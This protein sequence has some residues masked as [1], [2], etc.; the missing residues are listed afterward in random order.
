VLGYVDA[1]SSA[2][3][4]YG[5][6]YDRDLQYSVDVIEDTHVETVS[7]GYWVYLFSNP[8][9]GGGPYVTSSVAYHV[10]HEG[11]ILEVK[12]QAVFTDPNPDDLFVE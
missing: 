7:D 12:S 9:Y 6:E 2:Y 8:V 5:L 1:L 11:E 3:R 4:L 10:S